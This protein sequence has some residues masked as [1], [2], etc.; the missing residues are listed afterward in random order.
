[1]GNDLDR[2]SEICALALP[3]NDGMVNLSGGD[4]VGLGHM[5]AQEPLV[6]SEVEVCLR[7]VIRNVALAVLIGIQC[8]RVYV[9]VGVK[10]LDGDS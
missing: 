8:T 5:N 9:D 2:L 4:I 6:M 3:G 10:F 1:M 7:T